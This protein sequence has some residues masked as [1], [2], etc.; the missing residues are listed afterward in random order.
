MMAAVL[1]TKCNFLWMV[2][3]RYKQNSR[4]VQDEACKQESKCMRNIHMEVE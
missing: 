2:A 3:K 1:V 4:V